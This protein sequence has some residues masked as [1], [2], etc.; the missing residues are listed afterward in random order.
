MLAEFGRD[1]DHAYI[2]IVVRIE[3]TSRCEP[4]FHQVG[5]KAIERVLGVARGEDTTGIMGF[6]AVRLWHEYERGSTDVLEL[7]L[8]YN[9][10]NVV[11]LGKII[12]PCAS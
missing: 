9:W 11:S 7:L 6:D 10:E 1:C 12:E 2:S 8:K 5:L 4:V 3:I